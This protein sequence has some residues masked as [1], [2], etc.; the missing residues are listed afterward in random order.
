MSGVADGGD[1]PAILVVVGASGAGKTTLVRRLAALE[2]SGVGCY[3]FD[4][5]GISSQGD[6]PFA[7]RSIPKLGA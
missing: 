1:V 7:P 5:I 4:D 3:S 6:S 2:L